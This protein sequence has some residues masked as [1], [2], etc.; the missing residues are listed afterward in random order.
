MRF[1]MYQKREIR[2]SFSDI[3]DRD[4]GENPIERSGAFRGDD[5][6]FRGNHIAGSNQ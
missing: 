1:S 5:V 6:T 4:P 3:H 2:L